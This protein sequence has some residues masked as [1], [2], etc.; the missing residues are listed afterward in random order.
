MA[1]VALQVLRAEAPQQTLAV[2]PDGARS[3]AALIAAATRAGLR[4]HGPTPPSCRARRIMLGH[5]ASDAA[6]G[7]GI[8]ELADGPRD[9]PNVRQ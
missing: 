6:S 4:L 1:A 9:V 7:M 2:R 3:R 5:G 8:Q